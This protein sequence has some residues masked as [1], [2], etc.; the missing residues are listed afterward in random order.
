MSRLFRVFWP[1]KPSEIESLSLEE[2]R[3]GIVILYCPSCK[4]NRKFQTYSGVAEGDRCWC[5]SVDYEHC[6]HPVKPCK[7]D[8]RR[9]FVKVR[10]GDLVFRR[11]WRVCLKCEF[12]KWF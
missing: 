6:G 2:L 1:S 11:Y 5:G 9:P 4:E 12:A 3:S 10:G 8:L 7:P